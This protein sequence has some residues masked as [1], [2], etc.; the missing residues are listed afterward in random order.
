MERKYDMY[1]RYAL[2]MGMRSVACLGMI[3]AVN[4]P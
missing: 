3:Q 2:R 4:R 1:I